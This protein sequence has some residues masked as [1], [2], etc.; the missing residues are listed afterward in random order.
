M[1]SVQVVISLAACHS[2]K[3][4]QFDVKNVFL[5]GEIDKDIYMGQLL[6]YIS[7]S[8]PEYVCKLQKALYGLK[9]AP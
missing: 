5:Y 8:H 6:G 3:L 2:W 1:S 9:Q 7:N 4:W